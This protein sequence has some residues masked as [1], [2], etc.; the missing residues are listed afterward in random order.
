MGPCVY[1]LSW[2]CREV[3]E[4]S[5]VNKSSRGLGLVDWNEWPS[6]ESLWLCNI[7]ALLRPVWCSEI[8]IW[9]VLQNADSSLVE[10]NVRPR[11]LAVDYLFHFPCS[12]PV[13]LH[14]TADREDAIRP[15]LVPHLNIWQK[16][17]SFFLISLCPLLF[18]NSAE[19]EKTIFQIILAVISRKY[20]ETLRLS[21]LDSA[22]GRNMAGWSFCLLCRTWQTDSL[23][24]VFLT[25]L[26]V[27]FKGSSK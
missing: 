20:S 9:C 26:N 27:K 16:Q 6:T 4:L 7:T 15:T 22:G 19:K 14:P 1:T 23:N 24:Y 12:A 8:H 17:P 2:K 5:R 10:L 25:R 18:K 21:S 13:V 3:S 11:P